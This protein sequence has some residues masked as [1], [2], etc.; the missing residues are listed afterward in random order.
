MSIDID[1]LEINVNLHALRPEFLN[2][3]LHYVIA[4][5]EN[6]FRFA[7]WHE[8]PEENEEKFYCFLTEQDF[9]IPAGNV[10]LKESYMLREDSVYPPVSNYMDFIESIET[11]EAGGAAKRIRRFYD[12][13]IDK[14]REGLEE[15]YGTVEKHV[16]KSKQGQHLL[17]LLNNVEISISA[18]MVYFRYKTPFNESHYKHVKEEEEEN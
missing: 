14:I 3:E 18:T 13:D 2:S 16:V 12:E 1:Q 8:E 15:K 7:T 4:Q 10:L 11:L 5:N 6:S 9:L 17:F